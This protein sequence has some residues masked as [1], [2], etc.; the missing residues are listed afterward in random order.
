M[1]LVN[2]NNHQ[3]GRYIYVE[4]TKNI[5]FSCRHCHIHVIDSWIIELFASSGKKMFVFIMKNAN[6]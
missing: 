3:A 5:C 1:D 6:I 4:Q 2:A